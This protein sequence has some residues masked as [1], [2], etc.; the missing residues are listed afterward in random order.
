MSSVISESAA[1]AQVRARWATLCFIA[2]GAIGVARSFDKLES[3]GPQ[4]VFFGFLVWNDYYSIRYFSAILPAHKTSQIVIDGGLLIAH[5]ILVLCFANPRNFF[6]GMAGLFTLATLKYAYEL[7]FI[8]EPS[9]LY[10]KIK[11]DAM[12]ALACVLATAGI[13]LGHS[14]AASMVWTVVFG[15]ASIYVIH[16]RPLYRNIHVDSGL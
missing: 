14:F 7:P 8:K 9:K 10:R 16:L 6:V 12:G 5:L 1:S 2:L 4:I 15:G 11:I 13:V 3:A